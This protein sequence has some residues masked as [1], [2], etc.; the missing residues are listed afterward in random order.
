[1]SA[2]H[3]FLLGYFAS[4]EIYDALF[5]RA[6]YLEFTVLSAEP[7]AEAFAAAAPPRRSTHDGTR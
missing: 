2:S 1:M 5:T 3:V 7:S 6:D 4:I